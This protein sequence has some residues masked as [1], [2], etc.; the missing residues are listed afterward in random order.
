[1]DWLSRPII[2]ALAGLAAAMTLAAS[3][4]DDKDH[5]LARDLYERGEIRA[6]ADIIATVNARDPGDIVGI[7]LVRQGDKWVYRFQIVGADGRRAMVDV[8][9]GPG[10]PISDGA[11]D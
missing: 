10:T 8:D 6:L 5:D 11:G 7:D 3:A 4:V 9:A 1:M 2:F